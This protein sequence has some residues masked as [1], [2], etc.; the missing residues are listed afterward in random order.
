MSVFD[1]FSKRQKRQRGEVPDVYQYDNLPQELRIQIIQIWMETIGNKEDYARSERAAEL[2]TERGVHTNMVYRQVVE[3]LCHEYGVL[4]LSGGSTGNPLGDLSVF[5]MVETNVERVLDAIEQTFWIIGTCTRN[6][7]YLGRKNADELAT[8][9]INELNYRF[10]EHGVGYQYEAGQIIRVD[11]QLIHDQ[12]VKPAL[13]LLSSKEYAGAQEEFLRA[14]EHYRKGRTK[15]ALSEARKAFESTLKCICNK[16]KWGYDPAKD[17]A[18][19]LISIVLKENLVPQF[20]QSQLSGLRSLL[21]G[22]TTAPNKLAVH[23]QG[24][25]PT[26]VPMHIAAYVLHA[27]ASAIVLLAQAEKILT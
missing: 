14:H 9:A 8:E 11:S 5:L 24:M 18:H 4:E 19:T 25:F 23:G 17:T 3:T 26:E 27:T 2:F 12:V 13:S 6:A 15:E 22:V 21:E 1:I 20:W 16:R 10:T 7:G